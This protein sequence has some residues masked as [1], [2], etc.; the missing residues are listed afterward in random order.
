MGLIKTL[1]L[2]QKN[3]CECCAYIWRKD[4]PGWLW[5]SLCSTSV[6]TI[7]G[8]VGI[9][10]TACRVALYVS[11]EEAVGHCTGDY[12]GDHSSIKLG[13]PI[14][15]QVKQLK[16][17][18]L[19]RGDSLENSPTKWG[20]WQMR[21]GMGTKAHCIR[22]ACIRICTW[23]S[24]PNP[25]P[26]ETVGSLSALPPGILVVHSLTSFSLCSNLAVVGPC[27]S[28]YFNLSPSPK[29]TTPF[30]AFLYFVYCLPPSGCKLHE[31]RCFGLVWVG[32]W[33]GCWLVGWVLL[34]Y[35]H[36]IEYR[37]GHCGLQEIFL[38]W[39][40]EWMRIHWRFLFGILKMFTQIVFAHLQKGVESQAE[41]LRGLTSGP[42]SWEG[43]RSGQSLGKPWW[44]HNVPTKC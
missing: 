40:N 11:G 24:Q 16:T 9:F 32:G 7:R 25:G 36:Y 22:G 29:L 35:T 17:T 37:W 13:L 20:L 6:W 38:E 19:K 15:G 3:L 44:K 43:L 14:I 33:V 10:L 12:R 31:G 21:S 30:S 4:F 28:H 39:I 41:G 23:T 18:H 27:L 42:L 1:L 26:I 34:S 5:S 2:T 8:V